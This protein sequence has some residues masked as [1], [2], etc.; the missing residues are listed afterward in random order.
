MPADPCK[1]DVSL[2]G[3]YNYVEVS[4]PGAI[5]ISKI[6][7]VYFWVK[8][9]ND[10]HL[11]LSK[12]KTSWKQGTTMYEIVIGGWSNTQ[13][14]IRLKM[15]GAHMDTEKHSNPVN[16]NAFNRYSYPRKQREH[17]C[18]QTCVHA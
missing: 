13:S 8:T 15:Q 18:M 5:D 10:A 4:I 6:D 7:I 11:V 14:V 2:K 1:V 17:A 3:Q 16:C 9:C 12:H